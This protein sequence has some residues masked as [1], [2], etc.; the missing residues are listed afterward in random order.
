MRTTRLSPVT[1]GA[2]AVLALATAGVSW[3]PAV[4]A[5]GAAPAVL[6]SVTAR[7]EA[8]RAVVAIEASAPVSYST[9]QPDARTFVVELRDVDPAPALTA[10]PTD[11]D[12]VRTVTVERDRTPDGITVARVRLGLREGDRPS[13]RSARNMIFVDAGRVAPAAVMSRVAVPTPGAVPMSGIARPGTEVLNALQQASAPVVESRKYTGQPVSLDFQGADLR[14][15][16]RVFSEISGLNV[17]IDPTIQGTV[18][19]ALKDVPWDQALEIILR[20]NKLGYSLE[21][22]I[23][24]IAPLTVLAEEETQRRRFAD[25]QALSGKLQVLTR[26]LSYAK[27]EDVAPLLLKTVLSTRGQVQTDARTNTLIINDLPERLTQAVDLIVTL[28]QPQPQVEIEARIV[29][30]TREFARTLGV[31]WGV[32][33]RASQALGNTLPLAFPNQGSVTGRTGASQGDTAADAANTAVNL[34]VTGAASAIGLALGSVNGAVNLDIALSA[35]E[36]QGQG[37]LLSTPRVATQNNVEAEITQGVQIPIQTVANNTVTV[38]FKDAALTLKVT[39]QITAA[40]TVIMR[41]SVEN[42]SPD[43]SRSVNNIP[44]I[45]TQR[46]VTQVLVTNG[47]TTVIGGIY[48]SREQSSQ[49]RTPGLSRIPLLGWLFKRDGV[50]DESRELLIFITPRIVRM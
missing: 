9:S 17:V 11:L 40:N 6:R 25:E 37:R 20:A 15:V 28:D 30:T 8:G 21:G 42:A 14:A 3:R 4:E 46:A 34:G 49:D 43:F 19:V 36:R 50:T 31:Q 48:V 38:S 26:A 45:D 10:I 5:A 44:P 39:P 23:V 47:E 1:L 2:A 32:G 33:A 41:I 35:L 13:A 7:V 24:R 27:A 22:T 16:L 18:D 29:Q 12:G